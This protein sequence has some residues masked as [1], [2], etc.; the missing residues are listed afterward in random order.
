MIVMEQV[1]E[2]VIGENA[3]PTGYV[4]EEQRDDGR[5]VLRPETAVERMHREHGSRP[6]TDAEFEAFMAEHGPYML[7]PDD[8]G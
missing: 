7:P 2:L 3:E 8:E 1:I 5:I 4:I 6:A